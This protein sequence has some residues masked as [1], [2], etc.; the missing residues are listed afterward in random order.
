[1]NSQKS[2]SSLTL[3]ILGSVMLI[4]GVFTP[5]VSIMGRSVDYFQNWEGDGIFVIA[6]GIASFVFVLLRWFGFLWITSL[7]SLGL[8]CYSLIDF[9]S[10]IDNA[11]ASIEETS[12]A[13][14]FDSLRHHVIDSIG[15]SWG[16]AVLFS[17]AFLLMLSA[18]LSGSNSSI[19]GS[20]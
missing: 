5:L 2:S 13:G 18:A 12:K 11:K 20:Q 3:G 10:R 16:W 15:F 17:G 1:M 7:S 6:I 14:M 9:S 4:G 19:E 8:I